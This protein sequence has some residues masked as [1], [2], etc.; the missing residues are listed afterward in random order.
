MIMEDCSP[1]RDSLKGPYCEKAHVF[2]AVAQ[3]F[4]YLSLR[5]KQ[6]KTLKTG[7]SI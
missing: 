2:S 5:E 3:T 1:L 7:L 4:V 6:A